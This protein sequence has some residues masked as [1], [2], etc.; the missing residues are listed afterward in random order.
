[1]LTVIPGYSY[2][3]D[4]HGVGNGCQPLEFIK[5]EDNNVVQKGTTNEELLDVLIHRME[6]FKNNHNSFECHKV[7]QGLKDIKDTLK[8]VNPNQLY[9]FQ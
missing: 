7:L 6:F 9:K 2:T 1:M 8:Q 4:N 5:V 3:V